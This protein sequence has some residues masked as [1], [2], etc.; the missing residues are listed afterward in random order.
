MLGK[1]ICTH[2]RDADERNS[3][4]KVKMHYFINETKSKM[5]AN[6][7]FINEADRMR[8]HCVPRIFFIISIA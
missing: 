1:I 6:H 2:V 8:F 7:S 3:I 4:A 5:R